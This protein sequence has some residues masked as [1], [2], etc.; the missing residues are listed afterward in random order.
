ME[1]L[2]TNPTEMGPEQLE[3]SVIVEAELLHVMKG[4]VQDGFDYR[5]VLTGMMTATV[6]MVSN[7]LGRDQVPVN[8]GRWAYLTSHMLSDPVDPKN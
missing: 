7:I 1:D 3:Q 5:V 8:F 2:H 6:D 4:L